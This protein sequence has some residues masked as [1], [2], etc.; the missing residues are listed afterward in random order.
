MTMETERS[1]IVTGVSKGLGLQILKVLL[2]DGYR[3]FGLSRSKTTALEVVQQQYPSRMEWLSYDLSDVDGIRTRIFKEWI[4]F[5]R[6]VHGFIN[7]AACAYDDIISNLNLAKLEAM[8]RV[9][10]FAPM[11]ITKYAIRH[12]LLHKNAGAFV[13]IS[14][15]S[16][17]TGY[18][19]LAMYASCKG[20]LEAFSKNTSREW[21][22]QGI[23]S[24]CIVAGFLE[25]DMSSSLDTEQRSRIYQRT[26]LKRPVS[27]VSVAKT[28]SFLLSEG[29][30]SITGQNIFV[31]SGTL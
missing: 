22:E 26:S 8:Y 2:A 21:G 18:R 10:V 28:V 27:L 16:A 4:G 29:A 19:G 23:R 3:V 25:T 31:D 20:A 1:I 6:P 14:S 15:A 9:N 5:D 17:H 12:M 11:N 30:D 24:N 7:N 13:H